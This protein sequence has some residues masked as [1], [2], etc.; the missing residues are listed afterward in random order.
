MT[1]YISQV[2]HVQLLVNMLTPDVVFPKPNSTYCYAWNGE[3]AL[4]ENRPETYYSTR[5]SDVLIQLLERKFSPQSFDEDDD[6]QKARANLRKV[7]YCDQIWRQAKKERAKEAF[8]QLLN[9]LNPDMLP[10]RDKCVIDLRTGVCA[11]RTRDHYYSV[12]L[13]VSVI[14]PNNIPNAWRF[15]RELAC[16]NEELALFMR[17]M[18]GYL[19]TG[20][21]ESRCFFIWYGPQGANGKSTLLDLI[22]HILGPVYAKKV[23]PAVVIKGGRSAAGSHTAYLMPLAILDLVFTRKLIR[24]TN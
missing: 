12:E 20:R 3:T 13:P 8:E 6:L 21:T 18:L 15:F 24:R 22:Q 23:A 7:S 17:K 19:L 5:V 4:W 10:I 14:N 1:D 9:N 16:G 2:G 11:P